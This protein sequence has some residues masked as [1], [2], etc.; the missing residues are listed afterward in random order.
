VVVVVQITFA[1]GYWVWLFDSYKN[2]L[3]SY[4]FLQLFL[5]QEGNNSID[6]PDL[7]LDG[8]ELLLVLG[9]EMINFALEMGEAVSELIFTDSGAVSRDEIYK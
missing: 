4:F 1:V 2:V 8:F 7:L 3:N 5:D 6:L 9:L